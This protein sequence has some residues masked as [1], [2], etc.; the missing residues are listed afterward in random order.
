MVPAELL[1][2]IE[3]KLRL[4]ADL[5]AQRRVLA[6]L[7]DVE[8]RT[9]GGSPEAMREAI[10]FDAYNRGPSGTVAETDTGGVVPV[11]EQLA[12]IATL[13]VW[14]AGIPGLVWWARRRRRRGLAGAHG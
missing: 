13:V 2:R 8:K 3:Q 9:H 4:L 14:G 7:D 11:S 5:D 6:Y 12:L 1:D 10:V